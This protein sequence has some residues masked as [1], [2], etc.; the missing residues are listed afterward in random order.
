M[1]GA[2]PNIS[3]RAIRQLPE[4]V[5]NRIAAGEVVE[6]PASVVKELV[7]NALDAGA[8]RIEIEIAGGGREL[9]RV[10]DDGSGIPGGQIALAL[11]RHATS[12]IDGESLFSITSFGFRGEALP[13]IGSVARL[14]LTS[15]DGTEAREIRA[16][17][18]RLEAPRPAAHPRGTTVEVRDLFYATPARLKFLKS[19]RAETQAISEIVRRLALA[20]PRVGIRLSEVSAEPRLLFRAEPEPGPEDAA[21]LARAER[22]IGRGF[23][24]NAVPV[25]AEREGLRLTGHAGLPTAARGSAVAQHVFVNGRPVR[26]RLLSGA[27]RAA[28]ADFLPRERHAALAL[29]LDCPPEM[30]DV[31]V[32]PAKAEV[33]FRAP[34]VVRGLVI[35]A[36]IHALA[37]A[38]HRSSTVMSGAALGAFVPGRGGGGGGGWA[39]ARPG[40]AARE[41]ALAAQAPLSGFA[42]AAL[43]TQL[44]PAAARAEPA[45]EPGPETAA[46][47]EI[48]PLGHAKA[49]LH[50]L[51]ILSETADGLAIID[52]HAA[53]ERLVYERLKAARAESGV[54]RQ[55]LLAPAVLEVGREA[56]ER[57]TDAAET[58]AEWGLEL[59]PFGP[60][61]VCVRATPAPL[62]PIDPAPLVADLAD[63]LADLGTAEGLRARLDHLLATIACHGSVRAG[64]R[65][66]VPEMDALLREMERVPHSG[67]C[68]HGRPTS[69]H[70]SLDRIERLFGR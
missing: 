31:N 70:L 23:A 62:G 60:G 9:I 14:R 21:R 17:A 44:R 55:P 35:S 24:E 15:S 43:E 59:E 38:G 45:P 6:R 64:R 68:N 1:D 67:Q 49:Q 46:P 11:A 63:E 48:P 52:G 51:Y 16:A 4:A 10:R 19:D 50:G 33:R 61:A 13:S 36:I 29:H 8:T 32:H 25:A 30:V 26:D 47:V 58:L 27:L 28:Y 66:T 2:S 69:V 65:L 37:A 5:A 57:L 18:G 40:A 20:V 54:P 3:P 39:P 53:H 7:E 34:G 56:A 12:K 41:A 42:E 22:V